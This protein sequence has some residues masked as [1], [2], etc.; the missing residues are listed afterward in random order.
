MISSK[1]TRLCFCAALVFAVITITSGPS[2]V[3]NAAD[4]TAEPA[5]SSTAVISAKCDSLASLLPATATLPAT[6][7]AVMTTEP[8]MA[9]TIPSVATASA[10][11]P[12]QLISFL[13]TDIR[14]NPNPDKPVA[15][16]I[17]FSLIFKNQLNDALHVEAPRFQL[18]INGVNWGA[19]SSTDFQTGQ[20]AAGAE[21][22][23]V[24]QSLTIISQAKA[25]QQPVFACLRTHQPVDLTLSGT[26]NVFPGGVK[27]IITATLV[28]SQIV[29]TEHQAV[30]SP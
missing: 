26:I 13:P 15:L 7:A 3:L 28:T 27:Q 23:I 9:A 11:D 18:A 29:V 10:A 24:L 12:L 14:F 20:L 6:A 25:E 30:S 5:A 21:Q 4:A 1:L 8:T 19:L 16:V 2:A 17:V 22:S